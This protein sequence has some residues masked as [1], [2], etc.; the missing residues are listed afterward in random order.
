MILVESLEIWLEYID[1]LVARKWVNLSRLS[2][3]LLS[4]FV[5]CNC[6][7][8]N[9][10]LWNI[11]FPSLKPTNN[12]YH[13]NSDFKSSAYKQPVI[14]WTCTL[15]KSRERTWLY[16]IIAGSWLKIYLTLIGLAKGQSSV[17]VRIGFFVNH[18][19]LVIGMS[20]IAKSHVPV[21]GRVLGI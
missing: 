16:Y 13:L 9:P 17:C 18:S 14:N 19:S 1:W 8:G 12:N 20:G 3:N 6:C 4:I 10:W 15:L 21:S 11:S 5:V 2:S 7:C